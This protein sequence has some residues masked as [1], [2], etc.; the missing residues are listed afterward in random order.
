MLADTDSGEDEYFEAEAATPRLHHSQHRPRS[1]R[2]ADQRRLQGLHPDPS[3]LL[4]PGGSAARRP[5]PPA[6]KYPDFN[7]VYD[8]D[9]AKE[10]HDLNLPILP[11]EIHGHHLFPNEQSAAGGLVPVS[12]D[13]TEAAARAA[14]DAVTAPASGDHGLEAARTT[15]KSERLANKSKTSHKQ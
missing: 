11:P 2:G 8:N 14:A 15:R 13:V 1:L 9:A 10:T 7:L 4:P 6:L 3:P 12:G 5:P